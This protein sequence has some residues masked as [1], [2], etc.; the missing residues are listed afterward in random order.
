MKA[1]LFILML[2]F[3]CLA[4]AEEDKKAE[5]QPA[6]EK[7]PEKPEELVD[8]TSI[9]DH[10]GIFGGVELAYT[11]TAGTLVINK[12]E[13]KTKAAMF[14]VA[15]TIKDLKDPATRPIVYCFNGGPGSSGVWLHLGGLGPKRVAMMLDGTMP[16][17]PFVLVENPSSL[18]RVADLV[19]IDPVSTGFS[20]V[21]DKEKVAEF[22]GFEGDLE[23]MA[24]FIRLYTTRQG[25]WLSPK[26]LA[27]ESYGSLRAAALAQMLHQKFGFYLNGIVLVSGV[28][29]FE[30]LFDTDTAAVAF[31][32]AMAEV[33][34][35]HGQ[36]EAGLL[37]D[38]TA[39]RAEV[40]AFAKGEYASAL[41]RG[42][43]L[44][45]EEK[46]EIAAKIARF[47]SLDATIIERYDLRIPP[48]FFQE[49]LLRDQGL[50][51]GRFDARITGADGVRA[52]SSPEFDPSYA[53]VYGPFSATLN[54]YIRRD[55][56]FESDLVY[57]ILSSRVRP[58]NYGDD[59]IG[60]PISV[61]DRLANVMAQNPAFRVMVNC[62][63]QDLATPATA[64]RHSLDHLKIDQSLRKNISYTFYEGGHMMYT[65]QAS[66]EAWNADVAKFVSG[67]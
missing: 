60:Q 40:E 66:N 34:A 45:A 63:Y 10:V 64:I 3:V 14:Y 43:N 5:K 13:D 48:S 39:R 51:I 17:P 16:D 62:G 24:E 11:A 59:F 54:D 36:L 67:E 32:P 15:Y 23:S 47:T 26:F 21:E 61:L 53:A 33:A 55:L 37:A 27:G 46:T 2:F 42:A 7:I 1:P 8:Q 52:G 18:L 65:I 30:T 50:V 38:A 35:Y 29:N 20:R 4:G 22:H 19:F 31:L 57:E 12:A 49:E 25:R 6:E 56:K 44:L 58:W 28:L 9:T 41:L